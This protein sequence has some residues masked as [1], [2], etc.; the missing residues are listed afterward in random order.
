MQEHIDEFVKDGSLSATQANRG[1]LLIM[2]RALDLVSPVLH[3]LHYQPLVYDVLP[4]NN[5]TYAFG[6]NV[7]ILGEHDWLWN[8]FR[9]MHIGECSAKWGEGVCQVAFSDRM[10][11]ALSPRLPAL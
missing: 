6:D 10:S 1:Q 8:D 5:D 7:M 11:H 2:D 9:H 4:V 3:D